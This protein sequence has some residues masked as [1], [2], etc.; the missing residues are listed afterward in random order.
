MIDGRIIRDN[1]FL[2]LLYRQLLLILGAVEAFSTSLLMVSQI[3]AEPLFDLFYCL[4][5][6]SE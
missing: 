5:S 2:V 3:V 4:D 1:R 6:R